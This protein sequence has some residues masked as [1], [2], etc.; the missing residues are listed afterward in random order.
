MAQRTVVISF[1][2]PKR[3]VAN[4]VAEI[5]S[6]YQ[7]NN[8]ACDLPVFEGTYYDTNVKGWGIGTTLEQFICQQVAHPGLIAYLRKAVRD[9]S[10]TFTTDDERMIVYLEECAAALASQGF[11]IEIA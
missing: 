8:A 11:K 10:Y 3:T 7:P 1:T 4:P 2:A 6:M 9:S 5:C